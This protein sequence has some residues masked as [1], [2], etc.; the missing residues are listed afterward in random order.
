MV[1]ARTSL[2]ARL[3]RRVV[4]RSEGLLRSSSM[5]RSRIARE[6]E[7]SL[8]NT[9]IAATWEPQARH[10]ARRIRSALESTNRRRPIG[11]APAGPDGVGGEDHTSS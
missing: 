3:V 10:R 5:E 4:A 7:Q 2:P 11:S 1:S 8:P 6:P 9:R